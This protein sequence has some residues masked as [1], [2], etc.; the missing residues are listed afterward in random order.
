[1][2]ARHFI[3]QQPITDSILVATAPALR[4]AQLSAM[5]L[6]GRRFRP[7]RRQTDLAGLRHPPRERHLLPRRI[8]GARRTQDNFHYLPTLSRAT[9]S[10]TGLRGH[11]Q[12]PLAR[13]VEERA[14][15]LGQT[16][17]LPRS[18]QLCS[19]PS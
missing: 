8:R 16:L 15:R 7:Q 12:E 19:T 14:A 18:T 2:A 10:W 5:A 9:E 11:V 6:P 13:I 1:M 17:P 3:L 4:H